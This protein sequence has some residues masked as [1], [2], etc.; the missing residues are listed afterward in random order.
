M[1]DAQVRAIV[2]RRLE[3]QPLTPQEEAARVVAA[4]LDHGG[5]IAMIAQ[6]CGVDRN[7]VGHWKAGR[8]AP[9]GYATWLRLAGLARSHLTLP[10]R[11][12][13]LPAG[14][15]RV[16][17][18]IMRT[19]GVPAYEVAARTG[20]RWPRQTG[21]RWLRGVTRPGR[22]ATIRLRGMARELGLGEEML[23]LCDARLREI[24]EA[25]ERFGARRL[26]LLAQMRLPSAAH[27]PTED[28]PMPH[29]LHRHA[30]SGASE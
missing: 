25:E 24:R 29:A 18:A 4:I 26:P 13:R 3:P 27:H 17:F 16:V 15:S 10:T 5:T 6:R 1:S 14:I 22:L 23:A 7:A 28:E 9:K 19:L 12:E 21:P 11:E 8:S 2:E 30:P 20:N